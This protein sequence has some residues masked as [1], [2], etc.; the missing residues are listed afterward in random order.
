MDRQPQF[1]IQKGV[2]FGRTKNVDVLWWSQLLDQFA[3]G[4]VISVDQIDIDAGIRETG[5][6]LVE[7]QVPIQNS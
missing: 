7:K 5:H 6:L 1:V 3:G 4:I 2:W